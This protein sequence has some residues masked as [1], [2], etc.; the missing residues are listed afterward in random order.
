MLGAKFVLRTDNIAYSY[1]QTHKKLLPKQARWQNFLA[2]F[3]M[4]WEYKPRKT[5][6]VADA[7]SR[8]G[9]LASL[10]AT[11][12]RTCQIQ[13][14]LRDKIRAGLLKDPRV[15]TLKKLINKGKT[16]DF[17]RKMG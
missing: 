2:E 11:N 17:G 5:N 6:I 7:L 12:G 4:V 14:S 16:G 13:S 10:K 9:E 15:I 1:F 8:K 3:D